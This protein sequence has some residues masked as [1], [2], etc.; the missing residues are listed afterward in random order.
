MPLLVVGASRVNLHKIFVLAM[1]T[2]EG[3]RMVMVMGRGVERRKVRGRL[4]QREE[5]GRMNELL[6]R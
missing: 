2:V 5:E 3:R 4:G 6:K 1:V